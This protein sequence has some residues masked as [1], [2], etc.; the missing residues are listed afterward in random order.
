MLMFWAISYHQDLLASSNSAL[1][2]SSQG[3]QALGASIQPGGGQAQPTNNIALSQTVY[4]TDFVSAGTGGMRNTAPQTITLA[5]VSGTVTQALLY[6]N[7]PTNST[8]PNINS[9]IM[10]NAIPVTGTNIGFSAD[11]CWGYANSQ[12]YVADVTSIV[13][14]TGNGAY[15]LTGYGTSDPNSNGASL[16]VFFNDGNP[17]NN[18]DVVVFHGNDSNIPNIYDADGWNVSLSG[19][20]YTSGTASMQ[21]HVADGQNFDPT[22]DDTLVLNTL[23]L[24]PGPDIFQGSSLP[25]GTGP[26]GN[27]NLWDIKTYDVTSYLS[28]GPNTLTLTTGLIN[29]CLGLVVAIIDLPA[30]AAPRRNHF[31]TWRVF[32]T[33]PVDTFALVRDQFTI[34]DFLFVDSIHFLSN[35]V[36]KIVFGATKDDT[37]EISRPDDHL[38]WYRVKSSN[39]RRISVQVTYVNQF[40]STK[41]FIDTVKYF[42]LP[43]Q[44]LFPSHP[45]PDSLLGHYTA[46]RIHKPKGFKRPIQLEDQFDVFFLG[47][48]ELI[49]SLVPRYF[50]TPADK[51][52][53][54]RPESDT[55]YVAYEIFPRTFLPFLPTQTIDQWGQHFMGIRNS[56]YL[57][58]PSRKDTFVVCTHKPNDCN[59]SGTVDLADVVCDVNTVF[60]GVPKPVPNCRCDS[61]ND[62]N[63]TLT[64]IVFKVNYLFK[65][66]PEPVVS[67]Q[68][69]IPVK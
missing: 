46:Y 66:G 59:G 13:V 68:C 57:L 64:D 52:N 25:G 56:E 15:T 3:C 8:D 10:V 43:T 1:Y 12:A 53:E 41:V 31:K 37:S 2:G 22:D 23:V 35:P 51:N 9:S 62:G 45:R 48:W 33:P 24:D 4:S 16:I 21:L 65:G 61:N 7:G 58:V 63:C 26:T 39:N 5:G 30:G 29:D 67:K 6:W 34:H 11:N 50:L 17:A 55:H 40:E 20:N 38:T 69:C 49:D 19:I 28:P 27:G 18:R 14:S 60:N 42:L 44:K 47:I 54:L 36:Q 32:F